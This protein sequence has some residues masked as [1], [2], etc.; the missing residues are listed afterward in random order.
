L[1]KQDERFFDSFMLVLGIFVGVIVGVVLVK[2]FMAAD[3]QSATALDDPEAQ[4][5]VEERIRPIGRVALIGDA[6]VGVAQVT[7]AAPETVR[8]PLSGPQ[9]Y[10]DICYLCHATPGVGGAPVLGDAAAWAPRMAQP[11]ELIREHVLNGY[12]GEA[13]YMPAKGGRMDLTDEEVMAAVDFMF[14]EAL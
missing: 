1:S 13:G 5:A 11:P 14:A 10:N 12:Q 2:L 7:I 4:A 9:V 6:D 8:A 3:P